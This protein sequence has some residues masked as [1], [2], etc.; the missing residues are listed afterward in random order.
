MI[1]FVEPA[2]QGCLSHS[3]A[4]MLCES[5]A[6]I[7]HDC[8][9][10][11]DAADTCICVV[12]GLLSTLFPHAELHLISNDKRLALALMEIHGPRLHLCTN[13]GAQLTP[14]IFRCS[15]DPLDVPVGQEEERGGN[16]F[17][18]WTCS[19]Q[20]AE[21]VPWNTVLSKLEERLTS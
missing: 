21:K 13:S 1:L 7:V 14:N 3:V 6:L 10:G 12:A 9:G 4:R 11:K 18:G 19:S 15:E 8:H 20:R 16:K 5:G 2:A 17:S